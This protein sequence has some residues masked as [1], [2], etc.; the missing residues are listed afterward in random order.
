MPEDAEHYFSTTPSVASRRT[1]IEVNL[2]GRRARLVSDSGVFSS[3][4]LDLGTAVLL[5][6]MSPQPEVRGDLLDLGCGYGPIALTLAL[7]RPRATVWAVDVNERALELTRQ[8]AQI[9]GVADRVRVC[10]PADV[11]DQVGFAEIW[12][13]PPVRIGKRQL[14]GLLLDWL[15]RLTADGEAWLVV[16]KNLGADSLQRWLTEH[17]WPATRHSSRKGYRVLRVRRDDQEGAF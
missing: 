1:Q 13:N 8:N 17:S 16:A 5:G 12:S 4:R 10:R 15:A 2:A 14:H 3:A 6:E 9:L 11:P 7:Q